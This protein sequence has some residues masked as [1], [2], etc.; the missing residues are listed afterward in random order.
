MGGK[1]EFVHSV[2]A[3]DNELRIYVENGAKNL[4]MLIDAVR[5]AG[6]TVLSASLH[7][8]S[9]EDVFIH[10]TGKSIRQEEVRKFNFLAGAGIPKGFGR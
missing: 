2:K 1:L 8:Q 10:Y 3:E 4:P 5:T 9:L 7:E 6:S